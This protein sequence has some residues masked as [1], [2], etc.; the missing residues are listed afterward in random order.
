LV[1]DAWLRKHVEK[2]PEKTHHRTACG[3]HDSAP[4]RVGVGDTFGVLMPMN[5]GVNWPVLR[6]AKPNC[7]AAV[8]QFTLRSQSE[9][10]FKKK[11]LVRLEYLQIA[12]V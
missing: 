3:W 4:F 7:E 10:I 5:P 8:N 6:R 9:N 11:F 2:A 1:G 12:L